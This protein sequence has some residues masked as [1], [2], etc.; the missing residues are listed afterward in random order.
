MLA[1]L[2]MKLSHELPDVRQRSVHSLRTKVDA[3][4]LD[5]GEV[6]RSADLPAKLVSLTSLPDSLPSVQLDT[7]ALIDKLSSDAGFARQ[8]VLAGAIG[9]LQ[10]VQAASLEA[11]PPGGGEDAVAAAASR[12]VDAIL[13]HPVG[14]LPAIERP[15]ALDRTPPAAP[16]PP[17]GARAI[18]ARPG[19]AVSSASRALEFGAA[20]GSHPGEA[21]IVYT[22]SDPAPA[23]GGREGRD[24][25]VGGVGGVGATSVSFP[26]PV[27]MDLAGTVALGRADEQALFEASVRLQMS[28]GRVLRE[29]CA[30]VG[31]ALC[32]DLPAG[33]LLRRPSLLKGLLSLL[34]TTEWSELGDLA[35][36]ALT[37][38]T[39][40]VAQ[41]HAALHDA[42]DAPDRAHQLAPPTTAL[43][44]AEE[45]GLPF[46]VT[47]AG[48]GGRSAATAAA[49][50][51]AAWLPAPPGGGL[52][53]EPAAWAPWQVADAVWT[54]VLPLLR[55]PDAAP[56]ALPL[57]HR[58][59]P[60][61][62]T[63]P[64]DVLAVMRASDAAASEDA[65]NAV[66]AVAAAAES[67]PAD[68]DAIIR[69]AA[70]LWRAHLDA[71]LGVLRFRRLLP[72]TEEAP[73]WAELQP[74][75]LPLL[76]LALTCV[77]A[78]PRELLPL[79]APPGLS[80]L[81]VAFVADAYL[82][83]CEP[84]A[85]ESA[86]RCLGVLDPPAAQ[87]AAAAA[88][89]ERAAQAALA[90]ESQTKPPL[91]ERLGR[92]MPGQRARAVARECAA[93]GE[94][95]PAL[96]YL[97]L[98]ALPSAV[99]E[100][101]CCCCEPGGSEDEGV[102]AV[103]AAL[104]RCLAHPQAGVREVTLK[105]VLSI[106]WREPPPR[107][108]RP[109]AGRLAAADGG[110]LSVEENAN[111]VAA[112][113]AAAEAE[114]EEAAAEAEAA[115]AAAQAELSSL[116]EMLNRPLLLRLLVDT[117]LH[118][119][120]S[121]IDAV[122][123][124]TVE[125]PSR[126]SAEEA[127]VTR[128]AKLAQAI[129]L[130]LLAESDGRQRLGWLP[131]VPLWQ[132]HL[133]PPPPLRQGDGGDDGDDDDTAADDGAQGSADGSATA[134]LPAAAAA[135]AS[136]H[137]EAVL[138]LLLE[139]S[140][141]HV[142]LAALLR[143]LLHRDVRIA[144][145]AAQLLV[146][147]VIA[148][149][150][151]FAAQGR[152]A[153]STIT[154]APLHGLAASDSA[155]AASASAA[156]ASVGM[157]KTAAVAAAAGQVSLE[158]KELDNLLA[159]LPT[160]SLEPWIRIAAADQLTLLAT[161]HA[162]H[163]RLAPA[164]PALD[165]KAA[166][167]GASASSASTLLT[168]LAMV[169]DDVV[170]DARLGA[171]DAAAA[172]A[173]DESA[174]LAGSLLQ[175]LRA[176]LITSYTAR[177]AYLGSTPALAL[178][179]RLAL[180]PAARV[181]AALRAVLCALLF[182]GAAAVA[183]ASSVDG[184][185]LP[186]LVTP[187]PAAAAAAIASG[188]LSPP[189][190][191]VHCFG[192]PEAAGQGRQTT[193]A[194][195]VAMAADDL[196]S[197][198]PDARVTSALA[199][200]RALREARRAQ[201]ALC[202]S[203]SALSAAPPPPD[204]LALAPAALAPT[205]LTMAAVER[206]GRL[207][208]RL[209]AAPALALLDT[210]GDHAS[211]YASI[212]ELH[213]VCAS[214][215]LLTQLNAAAPTSDAPPSAH[216]RAVN[217]LAAMA[218]AA[219]PSIQ[220]AVSSA[221]A[222]VAP[223]HP[224]LSALAASPPRATLL[225]LLTIEPATDEDDQLL[226]ALLGA[227]TRALEQQALET[228]LS[229]P[230]P[231]VLLDHLAVVGLRVLD[232][233]GDGGL[234]IGDYPATA[235]SPAQPRAALR[236][237][238]LRFAL[239]LIGAY[240]H[241]RRVLLEQGPLLPLLADQYTSAPYSNAGYAVR[242]GRRPPPTHVRRLAL[243]L[244][245]DAL[246]LGVSH[247]KRAP[248][249]LAARVATI[250]PSLVGA[251]S[252]EHEA[253]SVRHACCLRPAASAVASALRIVLSRGE[254]GLQWLWAHGFRWL[255]RL[256][257]AEDTPTRA[258]AAGIATALAAAPSARMQL[259]SQLP[260][261]LSLTCRQA[262][263]PAQPA[264]CRAAA[265]HLLL[266]LCV[267]A[268]DDEE[269]GSAA[270]AASASD[271]GGEERSAASAAAA[272]DAT[273]GPVEWR[274]GRHELWARLVSHRL[275]QQL[276]GLFDEPYASPACIGLAADLVVAL[277][278][279]KPA[280]MGQCLQAK[281]RWGAM[282]WLHVDHHW[283][284]FVA[285]QA[286]GAS[287]GVGA[288][289]PAAAP[290]PIAPGSTAAARQRAV[291]RTM[292]EMQAVHWL[293][294]TLPTVH[295]A[296]AALLR[297]LRCILDDPPAALTS[298]P[299]GGGG[300]EAP[301]PVAHTPV[302]MTLLHRTPLLH[303]LAP[304]LSGSLRTPTVHFPTAAQA[305][306]VVVHGMR[307]ERRS[308]TRGDDS[309]LV[310][311]LAALG[312]MPSAVPSAGRMRA[313]DETMVEGDGDGDGDDDDDD[314]A[315]GDRDDAFRHDADRGSQLEDASAPTIPVPLEA[316]LGVHLGSPLALTL[317]PA[318]YSL[319]AVQR[320]LD[321]PAHAAT[322]AAAAA[323]AAEAHLEALRIWSLLLSTMS[324]ARLALLGGRLGSAPWAL[325]VMSCVHARQPLALR[326]GGCALIS[327]LLDG[328]N[329]SQASSLDQPLSA[330]DDD[331][332]EAEAPR[333]AHAVRGAGVGGMLAE[334][335]LEL[336]ETLGARQP[337][338]LPPVTAALR[339]L[340]GVS[341]SAK[342]ALLRRGFLPTLVGRIDDLRA[343][344][345][346]PPPEV[347]AAA[348]AKAKATANAMGR[349][350]LATAAAAADED[351]PADKLI[352]RTELLDQMLSSLGLLSNLLGGCEEAQLASV[353]MQ[354]PLL[355]LRLW[356]LGRS[357]APVRTA[358]LT[359]LCNH[360]AHCAPAKASLAAYTDSKGRC[361]PTL[362]MQLLCKPARAS[363]PPLPEAHWAYG[364]AVLR[365]L[366][367][368]PESRAVLL[369]A[370]L[371]P[372]AVPMLSRILGSTDERRAAPIVELFANLAFEA[373][374]AAAILKLPDA[375]EA[376]LS[377]LESRLNT[378]RYAAA[379]ALRNLAFLADGRAAL[380][381]K[382]RALPAL[383]RALHPSDLLLAARAAA[384]LW[385]LLARCER[386]KGAMRQPALLAPLRAAEAALITRAMLA[387]PAIDGERCGERELLGDC[388]R[389]IGA[390]MSILKL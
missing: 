94:C 112:A 181:R 95:V 343:L 290:P 75:D 131:L 174:A 133:P 238:I 144:T 168:D 154:S 118:Q 148:A 279:L 39:E 202:S 37:C 122:A 294:H 150:D 345:T 259:A 104:R 210:C 109:P 347:K 374:G 225:R 330:A 151:E 120:P 289:A 369:K 111:A 169:L 389:A 48:G 307:P 212:A 256:L 265:L 328:A 53:G 10:R 286:A 14:D 146:A 388:L 329:P 85:H 1:N 337:A 209:A 324:E 132:A 32:H 90:L 278:E 375:F 22:H 217:A 57:L 38:A 244:L 228:T 360:V 381:A 291:S 86:S 74:A 198:A 171:G 312:S 229:T 232:R 142:R 267:S 211:C 107:P 362:V 124:A 320:L 147:T 5:V 351:A 170:G 352:Y 63:P 129:L 316:D 163:S 26:C 264:A 336:F 193:A 186:H 239:A 138:S 195:A 354:L 277:L 160:T 243:T 64:A 35:L 192:L 115:E 327:A 17:G 197:L 247:G 390:V 162:L 332:A 322:A 350:A 213:A 165:A 33:A 15:I 275:P 293:R 349:L 12:A 153:T 240:P 158:P 253:G 309:G 157:P 34:R 357:H 249:A 302:A 70:A 156:S 342:L 68:A 127:V 134:R 296:R 191:V 188:M 245:A 282:R 41:L 204:A 96:S 113:A 308:T 182:D 270:V 201:P 155:T 121:L 119:P 80:A 222:P 40:L 117:A 295:R 19:G 91:R 56:A 179:A 149:A 237:G 45:F 161:S 255:L 315:F 93:L 358:V 216:D 340:V 29:T 251:A 123:S 7:L 183:A 44:E 23:R 65:A 273:S 311:A 258:A 378:A 30:S 372:R 9:V 203:S 257:R 233:T 83:I 69:A 167:A 241:A 266:T 276:L 4:L 135:S 260:E 284:A 365:S 384:A 105:K 76:L 206:A 348:K 60:L 200:R 114:A 78:C 274:L 159:I 145:R 43:T 226:S 287:G 6:C 380:L 72:A 306:A 261:V 298:F 224:I 87:A 126:A 67:A 24:G 376:L 184:S 371:L 71:M 180:H 176:L 220:G 280:Q 231:S 242:D 101:A 368:A 177:A 250:L 136:A 361:L 89:V 130:S 73:G 152:G 139:A 49:A 299:H 3:H 205:A 140:G 263:Q 13:R 359:L 102:A 110:P 331:E 325:S 271:L 305:R 28:D 55:H 42:A 103:E 172:A 116:V 313:V 234:S 292:S 79:A 387:T 334:A 346:T 47:S 164:A 319:E 66:A 18:F 304:M 189:L 248:S 281:P 379:L 137:G 166:G 51:A 98:P 100:L 339:A 383:L 106:F 214:F 84:S 20:G 185:R 227:L 272:S 175:L 283:A 344:A 11:A 173:D 269:P 88:R 52:M 235:P 25:G 178:L 230:P 246:S 297:M 317:A 36:A 386:A 382:P 355:L 364:W 268:P 326:L 323:S 97:H 50:A 46:H 8:I 215:E 125:A 190:Q 300:T 108:S 262:L 187:P 21:P 207:A 353:T 318:P 141:G 285:G 218:S 31:G 196:H 27:W 236:C 128:H 335:L 252:A 366:A 92:A 301:L 2:I 221:D 143:L 288:G 99:V 356:P 363:S 61:L 385:A 58:T 81:L 373:E 194:R 321:A 370:Q 377:A 310:E 62:Y 54:A 208:P 59:L 341:L 367:T 338:S 254:K 303:A 223:V 314:D 219:S 16:P 77:A 333:W 82:E 199:S